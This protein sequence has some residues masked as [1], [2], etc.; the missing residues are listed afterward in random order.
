[1]KCGERVMEITRKKQ[2]SDAEPQ[3]PSYPEIG[4]VAMGE[5]GMRVAKKRSLVIM[6]MGEKTKIRRDPR[7]SDLMKKKQKKSLTSLVGART[8][9]LFSALMCFGVNLAYLIILPIL[10]PLPLT[11]PLPSSSFSIFYYNIF[12]YYSSSS[13]SHPLLYHTLPTLIALVRV[14]N[15]K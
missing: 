12:Y 7:M 15:K 5:L 3:P 11:F 10:L 6:G 13:L 2:L 1:M 9:S 14:Q 8:V 4:R